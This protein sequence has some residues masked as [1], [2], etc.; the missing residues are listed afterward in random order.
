MSKSMQTQASAEAMQ[1]HTSVNAAVRSY[2]GLVAAAWCVIDN[3][4]VQARRFNSGAHRETSMTSTCS[5]DA[6]RAPFTLPR[7]STYP[8][9]GCF[10]ITAAVASVSSVGRLSVA[11]DSAR[12][13][14]A[15]TTHS[16]RAFATP[17]ETRCMA[18]KVRQHGSV[19]SPSVP[20]TTMA[21]YLHSTI[22]IRFD[23]S[24]VPHSAGKSATPGSLSVL[25]LPCLNIAPIQQERD[26][27]L[28]TL[29]WNPAHTSPVV[30][31]SVCRGELPLLGA[32]SLP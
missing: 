1:E 15:V 2:V 11:S 14:F 31:H 25:V 28:Q 27:V 18:S 16:S 10:G 29:A 7:P 3:F 9:L 24:E 17:A 4:A 22:A 12:V 23:T 5:R 21:Q 8:S 6:C 20:S 19:S 30:V 26:T 32:A 13:G